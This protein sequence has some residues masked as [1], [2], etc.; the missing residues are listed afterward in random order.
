MRFYTKKDIIKKFRIPQHQM[1]AFMRCD[2][3]KELFDKADNNK[4]LLL[5]EEKLKTFVNKVNYIFEYAMLKY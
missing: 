2:V 4:T 5:P 3:I 1:Q